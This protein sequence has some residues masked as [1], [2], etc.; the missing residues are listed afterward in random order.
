MNK[1]KRPIT[2]VSKFEAS[3][4]HAGLTGN[5]QRLIAYIRYIGI[6]TQPSLT[7]ELGLEPKPPILSILCETCRKIG[8]EMP[9]HFKAV[10]T[11]SKAV[12]EDNVQWDGDLICS[13]V[14]SID[15]ERL[16]PEFGTVQ[17]HTFVV[18]KEL[19]TRLEGNHTRLHT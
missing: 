12:S 1:I 17:F 19:F 14:W 15:G 18:H 10:R 2:P 3:L 8:S 5:E 4:E 16:T 13:S 9:Q 11:W 7:K 6:F